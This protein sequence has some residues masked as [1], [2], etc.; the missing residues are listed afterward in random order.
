MDL[1][2]ME[3]AAP[4]VGQKPRVFTLP[5]SPPTWSIRL[6]H[7]AF[8][9]AAAA[10]VRWQHRSTHLRRRSRPMNQLAKLEPHVLSIF[11][12]MA[13]LLMLQH[14][15]T[16]VLGFPASR[17]SDVPLLSLGGIA[18][19][20]ELVL[21]A[22]LVVGLFSRTAAFV[23]SGLLAAA[24]FIAHAPQGFFPLLNGGELAAL[25]SFA[26]LYLAAAGPGPWSVD[27]ARGQA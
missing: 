1:T 19:L 10:R 4:Q 22:L 20:L 9:H 18:G 26:F 14:G 23:L 17:M 27:A 13:G 12:I 11:R 24:Y 16:K 25:Y 6:R 21:G 7:T 8:F 5:L 15:T 3:T 2:V